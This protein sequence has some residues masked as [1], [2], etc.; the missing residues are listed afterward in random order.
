MTIYEGNIRIQS[1]FALRRIPR[2]NGHSDNTDSSCK[3]QPKIVYR[4]S[5]EIKPRYYG[6][7]L[8]RTLTQGPYSVR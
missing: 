3:S 8:M 2:Y 4:R 1:T 7:S 6:L 5:T